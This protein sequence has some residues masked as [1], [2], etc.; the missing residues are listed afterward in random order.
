MEIAATAAQK[1]SSTRK[2]LVEFPEELLERAQ[3]VADEQATD[4][5]K[6]IRTAVEKYVRTI[7][8]QKLERD[9]AEAYKANSELALKIS[10]EFNAVDRENF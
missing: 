2:V 10:E 8:R 1:G 4:R 6:L 3:V 9:L 7:E 5:S